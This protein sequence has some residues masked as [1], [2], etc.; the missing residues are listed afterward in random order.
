MRRSS[1][2]AT[3]LVVLLLSL[4]VCAACGA[5]PPLTFGAPAD[6]EVEITVV[7][8]T[9]TVLTSPPEYTVI[10]YP[11]DMGKPRK[12]KFKVKKAKKQEV[13]LLA[14]A[15]AQPLLFGVLPKF[16]KFATEEQKEVEPQFAPIFTNGESIFSYA[17]TVDGVLC[18]D[19]DIC[20][21]QG[22]SGCTP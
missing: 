14:K 20:I 10:D 6:G 17:V 1:V 16:S 22:G 11:T 2:R 19:P 7:N 12:V 5:R 9:C 13:L 18:V 21:R 15:G 8:F 3:R 4:A